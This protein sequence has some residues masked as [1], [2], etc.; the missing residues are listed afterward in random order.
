[1]TKDQS[2]YLNSKSVHI[3]M[4][5]VNYKTGKRTESIMSTRISAPHLVVRNTENFVTNTTSEI[6]ANFI[7]FKRMHEPNITFSEYYHRFKTMM[8][9]LEVEDSVRV[10]HL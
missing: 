3:K 2:K 9:G 1:M 10:F 6:F 4:T 8:K 7:A 5:S